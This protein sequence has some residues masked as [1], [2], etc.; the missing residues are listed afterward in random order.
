MIKLLFRFILGNTITGAFGDS[1]LDD[2]TH[3]ISPRILVTYVV[4]V[5]SVVTHT[6]IYVVF[7]ANPT[8][9]VDGMI[10]VLG[11]DLGVLLLLLGVI[12]AQQLIQLQQTN[13]YGGSKGGS[14]VV[15]KTDTPSKPATNTSKASSQPSSNL[16]DELG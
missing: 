2:N 14:P 4:V 10:W 13:K 16:N 1:I 15:S 6:I 11:I 9:L 3:E 8:L 12:T 5:L 7:L